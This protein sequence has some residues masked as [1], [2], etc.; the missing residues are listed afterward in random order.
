MMSRTQV[1]VDIRSI[2]FAILGIILRALKR[3]PLI[4]ESVDNNK[5]IT[6]WVKTD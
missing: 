6:L 2:N 4:V 3:Y 1:R 5:D